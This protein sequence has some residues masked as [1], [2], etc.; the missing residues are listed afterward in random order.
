[1]QPTF[2][3][4]AEL[5]IYTTAGRAATQPMPR[6]RMRADAPAELRVARA[7]DRSTAGGCRRGAA[8]AV[9]VPDPGRRAAP[10]ASGEPSEVL[11]AACTALG[12]DRLTRPAGPVLQEVGP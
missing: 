1:M 10:P 5:T 11:V 3:L 2:S 4:P 8:A 9:L 6:R 12:A 7:Q